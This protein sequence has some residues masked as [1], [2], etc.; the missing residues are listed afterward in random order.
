MYIKEE[1]RM[2]QGTGWKANSQ[3]N[4]GKELDVRTTINKVNSRYLVVEVAMLIIV[5]LLDL[6][7]C[8]QKSLHWYWKCVEAL[9]N[10]VCCQQ[11]KFIKYQLL[12][13]KFRLLNIGSQL[14]RIKYVLLCSQKDLL[15]VLLTFGTILAAAVIFFYSVQDNKKEGIPNRA[16][17]SYTSGML[18]VPSLFMSMVF[19]I[20]MNYLASFFDLNYFAWV[21]M[22]F[23][24]ITQVMIL[25]I[26]LKATSRSYSIHA[27]CNAE[28]Q[29]YQKLIE[30]EKAYESKNM[31]PEYP[32]F[33]TYFLQHLEQVLSSD[34]ISTDNLQIAGRLLRVPYYE[35]KIS[36]REDP[37]VP[38]LPLGRFRKAGKKA[39]SINP[40]LSEAR[41]SNNNLKSIYEFY[42]RSLVA[43]FR[44][45]CQQEYKEERD[46]IY[47]I[48]YDFLEELK[49]LYET[50]QKDPT[51][52]NEEA[53]SFYTMTI[54]GILNAVLDSGIP[55]SEGF[56]DYVFNKIVSKEVRDFQIFLYFL[57]N[58]R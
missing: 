34:E 45:K 56:C 14:Y 12:F 58:G 22:V 32:I 16:I 43:V 4:I 23:T 42:Y 33:W 41:L 39:G 5:F 38:I 52:G 19:M 18:A 48:L 55:E 31:D 40:C 47:L 15:N 36:I 1:K 21:G 28:I 49:E 44:K 51:V 17:M 29:Q 57:V 24:F 11:F 53:F 13:I 25:W 27:I 7:E 46:K 8:F 50:R 20:P 3:V 26:V 35:N 10:I 6:S 2:T 54:C 9:E 37:I 30:I